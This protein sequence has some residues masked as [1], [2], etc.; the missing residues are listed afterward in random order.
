MVKTAIF[1]RLHCNFACIRQQKKKSFY[2]SA[3]AI[4]CGNCFACFYYRKTTT[5]HQNS[6]EIQ[7]Y[8]SWLNYFNSQINYMVGNISKMKSTPRFSIYVLPVLIQLK[9]EFSISIS[10]FNFSI[11][12]LDIELLENLSDW[13][14]EHAL[15]HR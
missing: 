12:N 11:L 2:F 13:I 10:F 5:A 4:N 3:N 14:W 7:W 9:L 8:W 6:F 1:I 15:N